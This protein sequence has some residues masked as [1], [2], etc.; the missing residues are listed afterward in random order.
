M[1]DCNTV[2]EM[3]DQWKQ[4]NRQVNIQTDELESPLAHSLLNIHVFDVKLCLSSCLLLLRGQGLSVYLATAEWII[5]CQLL[6]IKE[7]RD[8]TVEKKRVKIATNLASPG[9]HLFE[10][11][12]SVTQYWYINTMINHHLKSF[13][14]RAVT[15]RS[16]SVYPHSPRLI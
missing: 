13:P 3:E 8:S 15:L 9:N 16:H 14:Q 6:N 12:P 2:R 5:D 10:R 4:T 11:H 1:T 7:L